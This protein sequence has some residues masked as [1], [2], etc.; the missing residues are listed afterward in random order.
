VLQ[1]ALWFVAGW[2]RRIEMVIRAAFIVMK[3][4]RRTKHT[5]T[6]TQVSTKT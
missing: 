5:T 4:G 6:K 3:Q 2:G 1:L